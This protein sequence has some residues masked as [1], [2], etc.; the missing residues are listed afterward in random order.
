MS[1]PQSEPGSATEQAKRVACNVG[2][3]IHET[4]E[5]IRAQPLAAGLVILVASYLLGRLVALLPSRRRG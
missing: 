4:R 5:I 1:Q 2:C 3:G